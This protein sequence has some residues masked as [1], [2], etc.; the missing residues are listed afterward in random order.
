MNSYITNSSFSGMGLTL[1]I[2][3]LTLEHFFL[4]KAFWEKAGV[5]DPNNGKS[6]TTSSITS[7][8][9]FVNYG[10]DRFNGAIGSGYDHDAF[11]YSHHS[12]VDAIACALA[13]I[14][15]FGSLVGRIKIFE[16]FMLSLF[17]TFIY[18][19]NSQL[20]WRYYISDTGFGMRIFIFG[21]FMGLISS[22][23]LGKK[24]TTIGHRRYMSIYASRGFA[25]LGLLVTFCT[26][27]CLVAG[28][29]YHA[30]ANKEAVL[31]SSVLRMY[32]ALIAG[33]LGSFTASALTYRKIFIHD[34]V[35]GGIAV[36]FR[37]ILGW[38]CLQF[39]Q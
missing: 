25:L 12:F 22:I 21:S 14:V 23:I 32:L 19:V 35:F 29:L 38:Y 34:L 24:E 10:Q 7:K 13:N 8:I 39:F 27:P 36:H 11:L 37:L 1:L 2:F 16:S 15:A 3:G 17:G 18:E 31:Y 26:F 30:S 9:S 5:S 28:S 4:I 20:F 6:F 33:V